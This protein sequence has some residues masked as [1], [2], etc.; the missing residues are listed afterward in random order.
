MTRSTRTL[1][2]VAATAALALALVPSAAAS[3]H[4]DDLF[5][6]V[7]TYG[8]DESGFATT[9]KSDASLA[10][11]GANTYGELPYVTGMEICDE[12]GFAVTDASN[13]PSYVLFDH[14]TGEIVKESAPITHATLDVYSVWEA[15]ALGDCSFLTLA[16][17]VDE[18]ENYYHVLLRVD[19]ATGEATVLVDLS[20]IEGWATGVA[21]DANGVTYI[22]GEQF[23][24]GTI[25]VAVVDIAT[26]TVGDWEPLVSVNELFESNVFSMGVDFDASGALWMT[27]GVWNEE[28]YHLVALTG[29]GAP[30]AR[31]AEDRGI[32]PWSGDA[33][34][35]V[36][37]ETI[38]LTAEQASSPPPA[39]G[40]Q[41][42]NTGAGVPA[43]V[44]VAGGILLLGGAGILL[45]RRRTA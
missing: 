16:D 1:A 17:L 40:P 41:L 18:Q 39:P 7:L 24:D 11:L 32:L 25:Y 43:G 31:I 9:S 2:G 21:T 33:G 8:E 13:D 10:Y 28:Q 35:L 30:T 29:T 4:T 44:V 22:F 27:V 3:A 19:I 37:G 12:V 20:D 5:T 34:D 15:D 42:A 23:E 26:G 6:W 36:V 45:L 38:P 14:V